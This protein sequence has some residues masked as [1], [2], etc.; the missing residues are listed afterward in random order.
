LPAPAAIAATATAAPPPA[1]NGAPKAVQAPSKGVPGAAPPAA[2]AP[3]PIVWEGKVEGKEV[4]LTK[5]QLDRFAQKGVYADRVTQE[6]K[7]AIKRAAKV[8]ADYE[9]KEKA[10]LERAKSDPDAWLREHGIDPD[11]Y[12]LRKLDRKVAEGKMTPEQKRAAEIEAENKRLKADAEEREAQRAQ[13][14]QQALASHLQKRVENELASAVKRAGLPLGDETFYAVYESFR[15]S[16][17]LGL[18]PLDAAGL[19]PHH[20]DIIVEDAKARLDGAQK[21]LRE[22]ALKLKGQ[23]LLDFVGKEAVDAILVA[24]LDRRRALKGIPSQKTQGA[25]PPAV[26]PPAPK[27]YLSVAEADAQ[28]KQLSRGR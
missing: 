5:A 10:R 9:A 24:E 21:G 27:A 12:A 18:L 2:E 25:P 19:Q 22:N 17:E 3:E 20:A 8:Q 23:A 7:E 11:E 6:G 1:P 15:E 16:F 26:A 13:E 28:L 14:K 4:R